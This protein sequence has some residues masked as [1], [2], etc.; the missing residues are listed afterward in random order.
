MAIDELDTKLIALLQKD[1]QQ[2]SEKLSKELGVSST[3]I[4]RRIKRLTD[5]EVIRI[6][7]LTDPLKVGINLMATIAF[8]V[9]PEALEST[10]IKLSEMPEVKWAVVTTGR[11]DI[12]IST[13]FHSTDELANFVEKKLVGLAGVKDSET[14]IS[15]K[16]EK[17]R[18][19]RV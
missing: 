8:D 5:E 6:V 10:A 7:A 18:F 14:F 19:V 4:R 16:V 13:A 1:A 11:Y 12:L 2:S 3:T 17:G 9:Q 15:L